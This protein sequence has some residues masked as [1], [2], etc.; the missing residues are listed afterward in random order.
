MLALRPFWRVESPK[1]VA[2]RK[3]IPVLVGALLI[4]LAIFAIVTRSR[5]PVEG[6]A[7]AQ[8]DDSNQF[9][10][11][12]QYGELF[13][14]SSLRGRPYVIYFGYASCPDQCPAM[15]QRLERARMAMGE[16][17]RDLVVLFITVD[18]ERDTPDRLA[19]FVRALGVPVIA[20]TGDPEAVHRVADNAGVY[21]RRIEGS[22]GNYTIEHTTN[23][24][25]YDRE[26]YFW[27]SIAPTD[28][29]SEIIAKLRD[30][31]RTP[32][33]GSSSSAKAR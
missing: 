19:K 23:A 2:M 3:I 22:R 25:V 24:F 9:T 29:N 20:L 27:D 15:L 1:T 10:L 13:D 26:G 12:T 6:L 21:A 11:V 18:P 32:S 28:G 17:G 4:A 33:A 31:A 30:A 5:A 16:E 8:S 14:R 7:S